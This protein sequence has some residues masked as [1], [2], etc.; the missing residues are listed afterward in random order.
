ML[1]EAKKDIKELGLKQGDEVEIIKHK[2]TGT[3]Y[4]ELNNEV[5]EIDGNTLYEYFKKKKLEGFKYAPYSFSKMDSWLK[6]PKKFYYSYIEKPDIEIQ[7]SPILEKG[8]LFHAVLEYDI[9][10]KLEDF[11]CD[12][13]FE[14]L[15]DEDIDII[16]EQACLFTEQSPIYKRI[17]KIKGKKYTELEFFLNK[18]LEP[19]D[20]YSNALIRGF[21]DL[22]IYDEKNK[23]VYIYDWKTG[24]KS[25]EN[26]KKYPKSKDQLEVYAIWAFQVFDVENIE[27]AYI[28]VEHDVDITYQFN[29][30]E[31]DYLKEKW[32]KIISDIEKDE[33]FKRL[34]TILCA[35]CDYKEYCLGLDP[36]AD[37]KSYNLKD[38]M[39]AYKKQENKNSNLINKLK[40]KVN[41]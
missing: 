10:D 4:I 20:G 9:K 8:T 36:K 30:D 40:R 12:A 13:K 17:K 21:I 41:E 38:I 11:S 23:K 2:K 34:P 6:C 39:S 33:E 27:T 22:I 29:I 16:L 15:T 3:Y 1:Y 28:F 26:I 37:P 14:A 19:T 25:P 35:W 7:P 32:L 18:F 24:G 31:L 5:Y